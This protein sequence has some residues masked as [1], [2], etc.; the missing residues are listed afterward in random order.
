[1]LTIRFKAWLAG[2][3]EGEG[4]A[5]G[6]V[7][8]IYQKDLKILKTIQKKVGGRLTNPITD[9][10]TGRRCGRLTWSGVPAKKLASAIAP[11]LMN[12]NEKAATIRKLAEF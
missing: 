7:V 1:M 3:F 5:N 2:F 12:T 11:Y 6:K 8:Y 9:K 10:K 4:S